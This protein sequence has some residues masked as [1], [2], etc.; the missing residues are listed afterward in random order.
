[1]K[2]QLPKG[3]KDFPPEEK[4]V[5]DKI[6]ETMKNCFELYGFSPLETPALERYDV[7]ASKFTGGDEILKEIFKVKDQGGRDLGLKY[8]LTVPMCRF[9]AMNPSIKLPFKRYQIQTVWR[10][11]PTGTGRYREFL[12]CDPDIVGCS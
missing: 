7:L 9:I 1:M 11:G 12:Q 4:I 5:R 2:L 6:V 3:T 10:D 8:D